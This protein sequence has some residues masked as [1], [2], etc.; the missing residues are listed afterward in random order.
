MQSKDTLDT[1]ATAVESQRGSTPFARIAILCHGQEGSIELLAGRSVTTK[2][3][4]GPFV[5]SFW[6]RVTACLAPG[7]R[8]DILGCNVAGG[9]NGA[10]LISHLEAITLHT[11]FMRSWHKFRSPLVS[12]VSSTAG[13]AILHQILALIVTQPCSITAE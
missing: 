6:K 12:A 10:A 9:S 2:T 3:L 1:M 11:H 5:T 7:G 4:D 13:P 8:I